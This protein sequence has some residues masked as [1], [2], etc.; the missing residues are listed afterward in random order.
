MT[1]AHLYW[2]RHEEKLW[3]RVRVDDARDG[4]YTLTWENKRQGEQPAHGKTR[5][6][7]EGLIREGRFYPALPRK[8]EL[9]EGI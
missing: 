6:D 3:G 5:E 8:I 2:V 4:T 9:P 1:F 7:V